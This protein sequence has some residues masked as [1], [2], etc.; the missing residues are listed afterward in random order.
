MSHRSKSLL[1]INPIL[2]SKT[3]GNKASLVVINSVIRSSLDLINPFTTNSRFSRG[4]INQIPCS[5]LMQCIQLFFHSLLPQRVRRSLTKSLRFLE[6]GKSRKAMEVMKVRRKSSYPMGTTKCMGVRRTGRIQSLGSINGH[7]DDRCEKLIRCMRRNIRNKRGRL[8]DQVGV[9]KHR[10]GRLLKKKVKERIDRGN[11][12]N[13]DMRLL[14]KHFVFPKDH[15]L[16]NMKTFSNG[17]ITPITFFT[18]SI[19]KK[20]TQTR[21]R[22]KFF[23][24]MILKKNKTNTSKDYK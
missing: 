16:R 19:P 1:I 20:T 14:V 11:R 17:I 10:S 15:M 5:S 4:E 23:S 7:V 24:F 13:M 21:T 6:R 18:N 9:L 2:L 22:L 8:R 3:P 12:G